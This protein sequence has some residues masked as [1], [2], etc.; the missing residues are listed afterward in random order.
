MNN[1]YSDVYQTGSP[2]QAFR[3]GFREGVKMSLDEGKYVA[4][5]EFRE[6]IWYQNFT[7]LL[8]WANI[9]CEVENGIWAIYGAR[10]GCKLVVLEQWN[11]NLIADY[12]WFKNFFDNTV[13]PKESTLKHDIDE[14]GVILNERVHGMCLVTPDDMMSRFFKTTYVN[15][16]RWGVMVRERQAQDKHEFR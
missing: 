5:S 16:K 9:G 7:R 14:L 15:P 13:F 3:S 12:D 10:L 8:I 4:P 6:K 1:I 2:F 11:P